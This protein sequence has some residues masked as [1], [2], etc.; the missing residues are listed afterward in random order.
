MCVRWLRRWL[1]GWLSTVAHVLHKQ[2]LEQLSE[3]RTEHSEPRPKDKPD[4]PTK[5]KCHKYRKQIESWI[6][7]YIL[8]S[9]L[10]WND[11]EHYRLF[12]ESN[13]SDRSRESLI[14]DLWTYFN[15][16]GDEKGSGYEELIAYLEHSLKEPSFVH[17]GHDSLFKLL[18]S[19]SE[20]S[21]F[22][23]NDY[24]CN[25][26][27]QQ[28]V[29]SN[30]NSF[31]ELTD[32]DELAPFLDEKGLL[33]LYDK[34]LLVP[35]KKTKPEKANHLLTELLCTKGHRGY[36]IFFECLKDSVDGRDHCHA[37]HYDIIKEINSGLKIK[38]LHIGNST[39]KGGVQL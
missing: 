8:K 4:N 31:I 11:P 14:G 37:G 3:S 28:I 29:R 1:R 7:W 19:D 23:S 5:V 35:D 20:E 10:T 25:T 15:S 39:G 36:I 12:P 26:A 32:V 18:T 38:G 17:L 9:S 33:T 6:D 2:L 34:K 24:L 21:F 22:E 30:I 16:R 27:I 13:H